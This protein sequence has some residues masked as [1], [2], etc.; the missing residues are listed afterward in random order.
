MKDRKHI[1]VGLF[2]VFVLCYGCSG[3]IYDKSKLTIA[4]IPFNQAE[5][6]FRTDGYYYTEKVN[7]V[8]ENRALEEVYNGSKTCAI[9]PLIFY[10]DGYVRKS[11]FTHGVRPF[12]TIVDK[13]DSIEV[14]LKKMENSISKGSF[15]V[16]IEN[17]IWDWG[18][19]KQTKDEIFI[20]YYYNHYG[21][22]K[23]INYKG[24]IINDTTIVFTSK[25]AEELPSYV[26]DID[27]ES[28][29]IYHFREYSQK[30]DSS[31]YIKTNLHEFGV[32]KK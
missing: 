12:E 25:T 26:K 17:T 27:I 9:S 5:I 6:S 32:K 31:N 19:Y 3:K 4:D 13:K 8:G 28:E 18:L 24:K 23:L 30:P 15:H 20:Q 29:E 1:N 2:L 16:N 10:D 21:D 11:E 22:Y 14:L 7:E